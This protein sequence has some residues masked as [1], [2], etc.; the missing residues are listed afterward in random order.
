MPRKKAPDLEKIHSVT[1]NLELT[2]DIL[3]L[4]CLWF[5]RIYGVVRVFP[6]YQSWETRLANQRIVRKIPLI[7]GYMR[8]L[9][10]ADSM[11]AAS[12]MLRSMSRLTGFT[13]VFRSVKLT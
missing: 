9:N 4:D 5:C 12:R 7:G 1:H 2:W 13:A 6:F 8:D 11:S 10:F 3:S